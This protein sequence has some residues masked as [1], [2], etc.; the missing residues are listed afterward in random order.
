MLDVEG[1]GPKT[2]AAGDGF[3]APT[4][5]PH[6]G[7]A[8]DKPCVLIGVYAVEKGKPLATPA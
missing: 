4:G 1:V 5:L 7:K 6:G 8:G 2:Y 3:Q